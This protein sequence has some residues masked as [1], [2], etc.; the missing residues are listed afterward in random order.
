VQNWKQLFDIASL[1]K[2]KQLFRVRRRIVI[3]WHRFYDPETGRYISAD[4]IGLAGG[5]NLY[6]YVGGDPVNWIDPMGLALAAAG[7]AGSIEIAG[8]GVA[9]SSRSESNAIIARAA[10][11]GLNKVCLFN[12]VYNIILISAV[13]YI[14]F[15]N[16]E[17]C[18]ENCEDDQ[19]LAD[20]IA[21]HSEKHNPRIPKEEL[22]ELIKETIQNGESK[23]LE[24]GRRAYYDDLTGR[25]VIIN[26][27]Q[28][29]GKQGTSFKPNGGRPYFD[30]LN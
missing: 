8:G 27:N 24:R 30:G 2:E 19:K 12:K 28:P 5:M 3:S 29:D 26:K 4:P 6:S 9:G 21:E 15:S 23:E 20:D 7:G 11:R 1:S 22:A 16:G 14:F 10:Q 25:I 13:D 17:E 18:D